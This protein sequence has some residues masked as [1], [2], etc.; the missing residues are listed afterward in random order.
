MDWDFLLDLIFPPRCVNCRSYT[1]SKI[2]V[3]EICFSKIKILSGI[4]CGNCRSRLPDGTKHCHKDFPF[5]LC[6]A[7]DY[8]DPTIRK[9]VRGIKFHGLKD[10]SK[11]FSEL[12]IS[13]LEREKIKADI[14]VPIPLGPKR[15]RERGYN[16]SELIAQIVSERT[17]IVLL[18]ALK[19]LR[20]TKPQSELTGINE[21]ISN[22]LDSFM[23]KEDINVKGKD[24]I[25]LDD[26][27]TS[28]STMLQASK[29]LKG[30]G[31]RRIYALAV[32]KA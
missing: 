1:P 17:G 22:V 18:D 8:S 21:R 13:Y 9:M 12:L 16:Q 4:Y 14:I 25:L 29:A 7:T 5:V 32:S 26:V 6:G 11:P 10:L 20:E 3:C 23:L 30:G 28:G 27:F 31:A 15:K 19:R 2:F 24:I